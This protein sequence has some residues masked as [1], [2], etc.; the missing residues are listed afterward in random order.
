MTERLIRIGKVST[1]DY[2]AGM[3][4]VTYKEMD[5]DTTNKFPVFSMADVYKMPLVGQEILVL[6]LP[7]GQAAGVVLGSHAPRG[8]VS[9]NA[10]RVI[11]VPCALSRPTRACE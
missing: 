9:R 3:V 7:T 4:S 10:V 11:D 8:R 1:V 5:E 2:E 6:H